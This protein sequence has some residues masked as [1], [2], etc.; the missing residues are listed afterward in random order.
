LCGNLLQRPHRVRCIRASSSSSSPRRR[1]TSSPAAG[2]PFL[3]RT[4]SSV[5]PPPQVRPDAPLPLFFLHFRSW[6]R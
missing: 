1:R 2:S 4:S 6:G 3:R 5:T